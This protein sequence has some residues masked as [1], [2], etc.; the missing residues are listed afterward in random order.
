M[1]KSRKQIEPE[2]W[3]YARSFLH[4]YLPK[5]RNLSQN[6]INSYKKSMSYF[7]D[8][9]EIQKGIERQDITFDFLNRKHIKD[10]FVWMNEVQNLAAKTCNLRLTALKSFME[11]CADEDITLVAIYND[12][13]SVR[14]MKEHKK[15]ILYM[16]NEA[17]EA[18]LKTPKT[19]TQKGRRNRMMFIMLYDTAARAQELVDITLRDLHIINVKT[20]FVTLTGKGNKSRNVPLMEKTVAHIKRYLQEF[21]PHPNTDGGAP[22]FYSMRDGKPHALSTDTINLLLGQYANQARMI[23]PEIPRHVHCH[24]IRKTRAMTLYRKGMPLTVIMEM[25][26]HES[27][28]TTSNFYA[29]ATLDM[30]H[31]AIKKT[32]PE[33][34]EESPLWKTKDIRKLIY[35]LD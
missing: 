6:T 8:Y 7:I 34:V 10:Y 22:L 11:Y 33:A 24:L 4:V 27:L 21:H 5:V 2:F 20:P 35:S 28:S 29:F 23:C 17:I 12:V 1:M 18:L 13:R 26:G 14:G 25:L 30:I 9:L 32:S 3:H 15:S 19:D 16:T 31:E